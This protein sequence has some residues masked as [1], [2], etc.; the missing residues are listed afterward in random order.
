MGPYCNGPVVFKRSTQVDMAHPDGKKLNDLEENQEELQQE[1]EKQTDNQEEQ[2][3]EEQPAEKAQKIYK[4][5]KERTDP[6][7]VEDHLIFLK[8]PM[9]PLEEQ[10]EEQYED[11]K[12]DEQHED[13][14]EEQKTDEQHEEQY[15]E[16]KTEEQ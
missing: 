14:Y 15:E 5:W 8:T 9:L 13:Q 2:Q 10:H 3:E 4:E 11:Q 1:K 16:H 6:Q 12:T 7:T